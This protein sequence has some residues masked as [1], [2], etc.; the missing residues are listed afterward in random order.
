MTASADRSGTV[1]SG[2]TSNVAVNA[3]VSSA[4]PSVLGVRVG[5]PATRSLAPSTACSKARPTRL[6]ITS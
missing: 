1:T 5:E 6:L 3:S 4:T 2:Y